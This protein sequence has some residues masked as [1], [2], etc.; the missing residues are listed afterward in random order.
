[1]FNTGLRLS[2]AVFLA[3]AGFGAFS[4]LGNV[5]LAATTIT[6]SC[7]TQ[8]TVQTVPAG[9]RVTVTTTATSSDIFQYAEGEQLQT[10]FNGVLIDSNNYD[11]ISHTIT[12]VT[13]TA[14]TVTACIPGEGYDSDETNTVAVSTTTLTADS[15]KNDG[16]KAFG[17]FKTQGDC[18]SFFATNGKNPPANP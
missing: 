1:M 6:A 18:V 8:Q 17:V 14:G 11:A 12:F 15:C 13:A 3:I 16:Y 9:T 4:G 5:V 7:P 10:Y 2:V